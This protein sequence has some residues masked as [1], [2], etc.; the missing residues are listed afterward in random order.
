MNLI[1]GNIAQSSRGTK[2]DK[3]IPELKKKKLDSGT[4]S[5]EPG[6]SKYF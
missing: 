3:K 1:K 5:K 4:I 6:L 2:Q